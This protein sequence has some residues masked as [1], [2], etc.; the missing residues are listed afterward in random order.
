MAASKTG[1]TLVE[2]LLSIALLSV[3]VFVVVGG[4]NVLVLS[5]RLY[6]SQ[7]DVASVVRAGGRGR[8][9]RELQAV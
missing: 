4:M 1:F 6:R 8:A 5:L 7:G 2:V 3:A 9:R